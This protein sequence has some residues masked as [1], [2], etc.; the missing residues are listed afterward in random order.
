MNRPTVKTIRALA[1]LGG[2]RLRERRF[3]N[4]TGGCVELTRPAVHSA[5][6]IYWRD[7]L[8]TRREA[9]VELCRNYLGV[10]DAS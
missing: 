6:V 10:P 2:F 8:R 7:G 1:T 4:T 9:Y 3:R 5:T